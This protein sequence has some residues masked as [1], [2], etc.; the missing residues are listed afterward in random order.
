MDEDDRTVSTSST[1]TT[2]AQEGWP[3]LPG[4]Q[5]QFVDLPGLRMHVV[6]AGPPA[7]ADATHRPVVLLHGF[8][9]HWWEWR[10]VIPRLATDRTVIVPDLRGFGW[11]DAP[12]GSYRL[13][14]HQADV[15]ALLDALGLD[16]V[17]LI[18]HDWGAIV[19]FGLALDDPERVG[20]LVSLIVPHLWMKFDIRLVRQMP[21]LWHLPVMASPLAPRLVG[22]GRQRLVGH[23]LTTFTPKP[24]AIGPAEHETYRERLR[25]PARARAARALYRDLILAESLRITRG[26]YGDRYLQV[27]TVSL[28]GAEDEIS[29]PETLGGYEEHAADLT[30][31][32]IEG[33]GHFLPE[34][35]PD[36][37][38]ARAQVLFARAV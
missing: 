19:A 37:V 26:V 21:G 34:E 18:A 9:E 15:V 7:R 29:D 12:G 16:R 36:V 25:D 4:V 5:H 30:L 35:V 2:G 8:P 1:S 11:S 14:V 38:V 24:G 33:A 22:R 20:G 23:M 28:L 6:R 27:P 10:H 13:A 3:G 32:V 17:D 31:E